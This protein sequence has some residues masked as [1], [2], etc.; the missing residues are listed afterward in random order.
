MWWAIISQIDLHVRKEP[1]E[2]E[3]MVTAWRVGFALRRC[4]RGSI[5][6]VVP[7]SDA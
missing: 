6:S 1:E 4:S 7:S 5:L 3:E 2:P